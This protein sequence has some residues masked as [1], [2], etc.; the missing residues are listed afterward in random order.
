MTQKVLICS[1]KKQKPT[2]QPGQSRPGSNSNEGGTQHFPKLE[3]CWNLTIKLFN[4]ISR[5]LVKKWG[6]YSSIEMQ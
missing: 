1:K 4:V 2:N 5:T 6:S 3:H